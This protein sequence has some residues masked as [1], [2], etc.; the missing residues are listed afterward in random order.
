M[1]VK[2]K[3]TVEVQLEID[4]F[5]QKKIVLHYLYKIF[6]WGEHF[7]LKKENEKTFVYD[8]KYYGHKDW[9]EMVLIREA[10]EQDITTDS[11]IKTIKNK[12]I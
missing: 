1:L 7:F 5:Q 10:T 11:V 3:Q 9:T 4:S 12:K 2:G 6:N 8:V